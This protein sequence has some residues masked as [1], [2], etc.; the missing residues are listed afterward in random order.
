MQLRMRVESSLLVVE[1]LRE[2]MEC[3]LA[4][5]L[6]KESFGWLHPSD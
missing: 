1:A 6:L 5:G 3:W 4:N 2:F